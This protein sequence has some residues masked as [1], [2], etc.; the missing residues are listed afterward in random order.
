MDARGLSKELFVVFICR[1]Q[2]FKAK[3][4]ISPVNSTELPAVVQLYKPSFPMIS[5]SVFVF[6]KFVFGKKG[7][8]FDVKTSLLI[9]I[10]HNKDKGQPLQA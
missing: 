3:N 2:P 10:S 7:A 8:L 5:Y 1:T 4:S 6:F 9:V